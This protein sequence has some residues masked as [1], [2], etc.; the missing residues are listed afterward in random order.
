MEIRSYPRPPKEAT[1]V[2]LPE[3]APRIMDSPG[4]GRERILRRRK[5]RKES[6]AKLLMV[7]TIA[8]GTLTGVGLILFVII[9]IL[10]T[11]D[12][13][14]EGWKD[15]NA[16]RYQVYSGA[17]KAREFPSPSSEEV[18]AT[19]RKVLAMRNAGDFRDLVRLKGMSEAEAVDFLTRLTAK[20][21]KITQVTW[22]SADTVNGL[23]L[24]SA[25]VEFANGMPRVAYLT[26]DGAGTWQMDLASFASHGSVNWDELYAGGARTA[27]LRAVANK[28]SYY[29]GS[30]TDESTWSAY[31]LSRPDEERAF[32]GYC[33]K[34]GSADRAFER[35]LREKRVF[36]VV[37]QI[38]KTTGE[39]SRQ[40]EILSVLAEG[41][42]L[43]NTPFDE[44][45]LSEA[46][47]EGK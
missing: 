33:K 46:P 45:F 31:L 28:D 47:P 23:Q 42:V 26:P 41:W 36:P 20:M 30:Y 5:V 18:V 1:G 9:G 39:N 14:G 24:E 11:K 25:L 21:G 44:A 15:P 34:G 17:K 29:N 8:F 4:R 13:G 2:K 38:S 7:R 32:I 35:V 19:V 27:E 3:E 43:T 40:V 10:R 12:D 6:R 16:S 22:Q 37:V